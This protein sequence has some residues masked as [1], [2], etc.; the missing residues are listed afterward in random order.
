MYV[1][2]VASA[3][4]LFRNRHSILVVYVALREIDYYVCYCLYFDPMED[5]VLNQLAFH[6]DSMV[7]F[8]VLNRHRSIPV[9]Y[10]LVGPMSYVDVVVMVAVMY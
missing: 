6:V 3:Y 4:F 2:H 9:I 8:A 10:L 7:L 1:I 5:F